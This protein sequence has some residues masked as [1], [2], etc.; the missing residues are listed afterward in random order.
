MTAGA[1]A[2]GPVIDW[3]V[4]REAAVEAASHSYSPYSGFAV[5]A[6]FSVVENG[7][8]LHTLADANLMHAVR[9]IAGHLHPEQVGPA[10]Q[11]ALAE[12]EERRRL[13]GEQ[14]LPPFQETKRPSSVPAKR[15]S[16][17]TLSSRTTRVKVWSGMP[18]SILVQLAP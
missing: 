17:R 3:D 7:W 8:Y 16:R 5:G 1:A 6:G 15:R 18:L 2:G 12:A 11:R 10:A 9:L 13:A 4:L 14:A